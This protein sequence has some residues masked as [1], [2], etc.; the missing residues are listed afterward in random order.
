VTLHR[1]AFLDRDGTI[2][3]DVGYLSDPAQVRLRPG[4]ATAIAA[5]RAASFRVVVVTNQSG[6]A[7]GRI[8]WS[9]YRAVAARVEALLREAGT[10]LDATFVCPHHPDF[11]GPCEC[12]K[13]G[14]QLYREAALLGGLALAES[15]WIG[16]Q[17]RDVEPAAALGG[18]GYLIGSAEM[19][20]GGT[21]HR[22]ADL[23]EAA[24][25]AVAR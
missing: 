15:V 18:E 22:V 13:P 5:L 19:A 6:I 9:E 23:A 8:R 10:G 20:A 12:R 16:D 2:I 21:W 25:R 7:R 11:T 24:R 3:D 4:A 14:L 1:A 17:P